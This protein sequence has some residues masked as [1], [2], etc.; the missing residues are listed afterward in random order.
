MR[1]KTSFVK[2]QNNIR[3]PAKKTKIINALKA[4]SKTEDDF[5]QAVVQKAMYGGKDGDGEAVIMNEVQKRLYPVP[6]ATMPLIDVDVPKDATNL[7]RADAIIKEVAEGGIPIDIGKMFLDMLDARSSVE[8]R[9]EL[10]DR[11]AMLEETIE[12]FM[13]KK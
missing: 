5:W 1:T 4:I 11:V 6:K 2:G 8:E 9:Q 3:G 10:Q 13:A 12:K 7:E